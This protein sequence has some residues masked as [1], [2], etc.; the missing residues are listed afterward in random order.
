M[1][2]NGKSVL[3]TGGSGFIGSHIVERLLEEGYEVTVYD[4]AFKEPQIEQF[5]GMVHIVRGDILDGKRLTEV[6]RNIDIISHQAAALDVSFEA[7]G[8]I[9]EN[10]IRGSLAVFDAG[11]RAGVEKIVY[12]S[13]ETVYGEAQYIPEDEN[14]PTNPLHSYG[15]SKLA[16]EKF[17]H[18][19]EENSGIP[20]VGLRYSNV[21]GPREWYGRVLTVFLRRA[22]DGKPPVVF[23]GDQLRD[24]IY[25]TDIVVFHNL[26]LSREVTN[27]GLYNVST[28]VATSIRDLALL[29]CDLF[30]V[31]PPVYANADTGELDGEDG[32]GRKGGCMRMVLDNIKAKS[33]GWEPE[34]SL[35]E[36]IL[37]EYAWLEEYPEA[38]SP[39]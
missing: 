20:M 16:I 26:V 1:A 31:G 32:I 25:V 35:R 27:G 15:V 21:Y 37:R 22:L 36:G 28:G 24:F 2:V 6:C 39:P 9:L 18:V 29:I 10:N 8:K 17:A 33:L 5:R 13:S 34:V 19:Y 30:P 12:A 3:I 23:G 11:I 7:T 38:W 4:A 14:H